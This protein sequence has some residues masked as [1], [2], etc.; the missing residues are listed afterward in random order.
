MSLCGTNESIKSAPLLQNS[1]VNSRMKMLHKLE[2]RKDPYFINLRP[3]KLCV[4]K[5][6]SEL[7]RAEDKSSRDSI[8]RNE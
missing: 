7:K 1:N 4:E 6:K 3:I 2:G 5:S 8:A